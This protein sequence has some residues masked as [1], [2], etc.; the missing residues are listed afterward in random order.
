M[1][2][3]GKVN[4]L[5][6]IAILVVGLLAF[7]V[8]KLPQGSTTTTPISGDISGICPIAPSI[9]LVAV[10]GVNTGTSVATVGNSTI[11]N[12]VFRGSTEPTS[13]VKG[14][15]GE[16]LVEMAN[17]IDTKIPFGPLGC[18]TNTVNGKIY[19]TD[20]STIQVFTD[21]GTLAT[22]QALGSGAGTNQ[23]ASSTVINQEIK[24]IANS[25]QSSGDLVCVFDASNTTQVSTIVLSGATKVTIPKFY[26]V[27]GT[28]SLVEAYE[29]PQLI[30]G[31]SRTYN[32]KITPETGQTIGTID[33]AMNVTC[34]SKQW[35]TE[36]D[37]TFKYGIENTDGTTK[38]EDTFG[39]G[40]VFA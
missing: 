37:G 3:K 21:V 6:V 35:F 32:L 15:F 14:E 27:A 26:T 25:D 7:G 23:S 5:I 20:D 1:N 30:D 4:P 31:D 39:Y 17:Y 36:T 11:V 18:G 13:F 34:Y 38:Y 9:D 29:I 16:M 22:N 33:S 28:G 10:D 19:A 12:G 24:F 40:W 8:I 2:K